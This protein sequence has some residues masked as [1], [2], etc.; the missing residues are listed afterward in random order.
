ME[1]FNEYYDKFLKEKLLT[2]EAPTGYSTGLQ[3]K[4]KQSPEPMQA[5]VGGVDVT[6]DKSTNTATASGKVGDTDV[7][8]KGSGKTGDV[9]ATASAKSSD[10]SS[11]SFAGSTNSSRPNA[12]SF[13]DKQGTSITASDDD[14]DAWVSVKGAPVKR[15]SQMSKKELQMMSKEPTMDQL[16]NIMT[17]ARL[18]N[19]EYVEKAV[20]GVIDKVIAKMESYMGGSWTRLN[21][22]YM[23]LEKALKLH[24]IRR[25]ELNK[26][27]TDK[28]A[29]ETFDPADELYTRVVETND[30]VFTLAKATM[31]QKKPTVDTETMIANLPEELKERLN[32]LTDDMLPELTKAIELLTEKYT[33][34]YEPEEVKP[35][36]RARRKTKF[37]ELGENITEEN[38]EDNY[39]SKEFVSLFKKFF[40]QY[41][42]ELDYVKNI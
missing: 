21:T 40:N 17:E 34:T 27:I 11:M 3:G 13:T 39:Y 12:I 8:M 16:L 18:P 35:A 4:P 14:N 37:P 28:I 5:K 33:T 1:K 24:Q 15:L 41:D 26:Q 25:D 30:A 20:K 7:T 2:K 22:R 23:R 31:R 19:V 6:Y 9:D 29:S 10:G 38:Q 42:K 36:L 32:F